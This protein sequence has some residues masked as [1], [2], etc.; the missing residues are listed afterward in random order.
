MTPD[1]S[2]AP[3]LEVPASVPELRSAYIDQLAIGYLLYGVGAVTAFLAAALALSDAE[4]ALHSSL[5]AIGLLVAGFAGDRV[6]VAIGLR[7]ANV[8]AY[9]LLAAGSACLVTAPAYAVTLAGAAMIGLAV[10]LL[11]AHLNRALTRGGGALAQI[12]MSR[13]A[14]VAMVGSMSVPVVIGLGDNSGLGWQVAFVVAG[15]LI[16]AGLWGTRWRVELA[17]S[18]VARAGSLTSGYW[19]TWTLLVLGVAVEFAFVF[20]ASTLVERQLEISLADATLVAASFYVGMAATR[21][22][23]SFPAIGGRDPIALVRLGLV[24]AFAGSLLAWMAS[25]VILA[26]AGVFLGGVG[27]AFQYPLIVAVALALV[28]S[29]QDRGSARLILASG[30]AILVAPFVLGLAA[31]AAGVSVAWLLIPAVSVVALALS[32]PVD[33]ARAAGARASA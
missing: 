6:D 32:V 7:R 30:V 17:R 11:L 2:V 22:A 4:A 9:A 3:H 18:V 19:L 28:P 15:G 16:M 13:A 24:V 29:L 12:R 27:A 21:L 20:W 23:L 33:R 10:G 14:L 26:A 1:G 8:L 31:D 25:E 5:L